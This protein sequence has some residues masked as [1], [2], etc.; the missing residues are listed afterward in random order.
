MANTIR[1]GIALDGER[2]FKQA[3][4]GI[5][6]ELKNLQTETK[7]VQETFKGEANSLR[8]L[9]ERHK[10]LNKTLEQNK[11]KEEEIFLYERGAV[12]IK[13]S[14][15]I[16][17]TFLVVLLLIVFYGLSYFLSSSGITGMAPF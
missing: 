8:A 11:K 16:C 4:A 12:S 6:S 9:E 2:E 5:N 10:G 3:V 13:K 14:A 17:R 15:V 7:L 1:A